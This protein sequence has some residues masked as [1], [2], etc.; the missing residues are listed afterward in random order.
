MIAGGA[1]FFVAYVISGAALLAA[2]IL[3][4]PSHVD[5]LADRLANAALAGYLIAVQAFI[6]TAAFVVTSSISSNWRRLRPSRLI[7]V[8]AALGLAAQVGN[9][10]GV[11]MLAAPL[12]G[13]MTVVNLAWLMFAMPGVLAGLI[14]IGLA[15]FL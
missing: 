2:G 12:V 14:A 6:N 7:A 13:F 9:W 5:P 4:G 8:A 10:L 3:L 1:S 15:R 11:W